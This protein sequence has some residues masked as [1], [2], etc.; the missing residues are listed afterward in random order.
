MNICV[1]GASSNIIDDVYIKATEDLGEKM[2]ARGHG[3]VF[4]VQGSFIYL[5]CDKIS[6]VIITFVPRS[7]V[8]LS[9]GCISKIC[10]TENN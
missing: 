7:L 3:L 1:Y 8:S 5:S 9:T 6:T 10:E 4:G 2:A